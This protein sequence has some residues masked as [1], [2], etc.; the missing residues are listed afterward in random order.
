MKKRGIM[1]ASRKREGRQVY[2][3]MFRD[4]FAE[5]I[6]KDDDPEKE[7]ESLLLINGLKK[8]NQHLENETRGTS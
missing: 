4:V 8:L 1:L 3:Y 7:A 6:F 2:I 5:I